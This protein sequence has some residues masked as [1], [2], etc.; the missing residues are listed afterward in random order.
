[1]E[2]TYEN[3][4]SL[5]EDLRCCVNAHPQDMQGQFDREALRQYLFSQLNEMWI[6]M[7]SSERQRV[8]SVVDSVF[9]TTKSLLESG[10]G[11]QDER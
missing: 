3:Y 5:W 11:G 2:P 4:K 8:T 9:E 7:P 10:K 6:S 1:M